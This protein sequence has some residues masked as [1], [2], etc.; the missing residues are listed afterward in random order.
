MPI[1]FT[2]D[3]HFSHANIIKYCNRPFAS[4]EDMDEQMVDHWNALVGPDDEVYHLGDFTLG[5]G[6]R[7]AKW[8]ARL[9][10]R[11]KVLP[12]SHDH[13]WLADYKPGTASLS[14]HPVEVLP[15]LVSLEFPELGDGEH[16]RVVV[17]CHYAMRAWDRSHYGSWHLYGHSHGTLPGYGLSIEV[18]VDCWDFRPVSLETV[19]EKMREL[20]ASVA[21]DTLG[22]AKAT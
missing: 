4:V 18:A 14:G 15:P 1:F 16:P 5:D 10:G 2:S 6:R 17:L 8:I 3:T 19:A 22:K 9:N 11:I 20:K 21:V 13:A 7:F 12:G